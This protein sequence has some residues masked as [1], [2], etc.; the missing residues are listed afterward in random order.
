MYQATKNFCSSLLGD[1]RA[2]QRFDSDGP[3]MRHLKS[4]GLLRESYETKVIREQ[5]TTPKPRKKRA[6][7]RDVDNQAND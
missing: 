5:P 1:V 2:G 6:V 3:H 7:K 4:I